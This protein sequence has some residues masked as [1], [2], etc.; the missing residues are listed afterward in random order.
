[1]PKARGVVWD[2]TA[3]EAGGVAVPMDFG[4]PIGTGINSD[5]VRRELSAWPD[6]ELVGFLLDGAQL[7]ADVPLRVAL[8]PHLSP[9]A[10][11]YGSV[12]EEIV[13]LPVMEGCNVLYNLLPALPIRTEPQGPTPAQT[14]ARS[15][16]PG[17]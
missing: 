11:A 17:F 8:C 16:P 5:T 3:F 9:L 15:A 12:Q 7:R 13:Q 1:M 6:Q 14:G 4:A 2:C 10:A